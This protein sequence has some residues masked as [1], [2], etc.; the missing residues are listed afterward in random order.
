MTQADLDAAVMASERFQSGVL[1]L[2]RRSVLREMPAISESPTVDGLENVDWAYLLFCCS[3]LTS[4]T[5]ADVQDAALRILQGC[6]QND[7]SPLR[8]QA[9]RTM[10]ERTGNQ[11]AI[12]LAVEREILRDANLAITPAPVQ[13][14]SIRKRLELTI[15]LNSG[16]VIHGN[17]FQARFWR[18]A[19]ENDWLSVSAPTSAG[20]SFIVKQWFLHRAFASDT[21]RGVYL[22]PTRALID[23]VSRDLRAYFPEDVP[24][25]TSPWDGG[26]QTLARVVYVLTQER[27]HLL[28]HLD[29]RFKADLLFL[30]EA[31]KFGDDSRGVLLE[32]VLEE[33]TRRNP[34]A[35]V[36]FASPLSSDPESLLDGSPTG[37]AQW[38][39][40][41]GT[42]TV[43]QNLIW[44]NQVP[45][46]PR[47]WSAE[48]LHQGASS[49]LGTFTLPYK[50]EPESQRISL[51]A[52]TLGGDGP[53]NLVYA[54]GAA[55]AEKTAMQ[56]YEA[57]APDAYVG[58]DPG[59]VALVEL[60]RDSVHQQYALAQYLDRG[61]AFHYGN[62]PL[63][64]RAE[65]EDLFR[66]GT[67]KYLVCTSTLLEGVN[68]PCR[69]IFTRGPKKGNG[70][71]MTPHDFWNLAGRA[72][73]WGKEFQGNI[74]CVDTSRSALW[75]TPPSVRV[76]QPL[77]RAADAALST[78]SELIELI[79]AGTTYER[80][81]R[82]RLLE[83]VYS[84]LASLVAQGISLQ[85]ARILGAATD[86]LAELEV[87]IESA[88]DRVEVPAAIISRHNGV[89]P[90][91]MQNLLQR[92]RSQ[93]DA[94]GLRLPSPSSSDAVTGYRF[95]LGEVQDYLGHE[96]GTSGR[97]WQLAYLIVNWMRGYPLSR[98]IRER[99]S[100]E[101]REGRNF[102]LPPLIRGVMTDVEQV[103]RF[104]APKYLSC[105]SSILE[106]HLGE[107][108]EESTEPPVDIE[109]M[110]ELGVS[111]TTSIS[112]IRLGLSRT[113]A[114]AVS[115][116]ILDDEL[117][118][119]EA[120]RWLAERPIDAMDLPLLVRREIQAVLAS[121]A[122]G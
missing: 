93:I 19:T 79:N 87:V 70:R 98:L 90:A 33:A 101:R 86:T 112:L 44:A 13:L 37:S 28:H 51:V 111:R 105:Y 58:D 48:L 10:L 18:A 29:V 20:K 72:G 81:A 34:D 40:T 43:N 24:V 22:V 15:N 103:A 91:H 117:S 108:G 7:Q 92:F 65:I 115:E 41:S 32:Q 49:P 94:A 38:S 25:L 53:G 36:M 73:R 107:I 59:I 122:R 2:A 96:F 63:L 55:A 102:A 120:R 116:L 4:S 60:A 100:F 45:R 71:I 118:P 89:N 104:E 114:I 85:E 47:E 68:L 39:E 27:L 82:T 3:A 84:F 110:L 62:M 95:A 8:L 66:Q 42:V 52:V 64:L 77:V 26:E 80:N 5:S 1:R 76:R 21:F 61:V 69:N 97:Q 17:T 88:L 56:I 119:G 30:D 46:K 78:P 106:F 14:D 99:E 75:P 35:Q 109:L 6:L 23:E 83:S 113:A 11:P 57:L 9:A 121:T 50:A 54:N 16:A 67:L 74:V 31:Q 12:D